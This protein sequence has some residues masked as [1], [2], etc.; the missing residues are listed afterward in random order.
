MREGETE[1]DGDIEFGPQYVK[2]VRLQYLNEI[3]QVRKE[4]PED[5]IEDLACSVDF[6]VDADTPRFDLY[7]PP[8]CACLTPEEATT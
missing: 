6:S 2:P 3:E 5:K 4:Y 7:N 8:L 1:T